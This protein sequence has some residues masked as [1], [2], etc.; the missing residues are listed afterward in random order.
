MTFAELGYKQF[1]DIDFYVEDEY[2]ENFYY[3]IL[4]KLFPDINFSKIFPLGGKYNVIKNAKNTIGDKKKVY[5]VDKDF[6]DLL[7]K[8]ENLENLFYLKQYSVENY[9]LEANPI[10][11]IVMEERPKF[12]RSEIDQKFILGD[13]LTECKNLF[14]EIIP[15]YIVIQKYELGIPNVD[16]S[17]D[18]YCILNLN[19]E[20][21]K[22]ELESYKETIR[23]ALEDKH[24][25]VS[26]MRELDYYKEY[27]KNGDFL[28]HIPGKYI[29]KFLGIR[30]S[31][32]F[33]FPSINFNSLAYRLSKLCTLTSLLFLKSAITGFLS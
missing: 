10:I 16:L 12:Q 25:K 2:Q 3:I 17:Q 30:I 7:N 22:T 15:C 26:F 29:I 6:D 31:Q 33:N 4:K 18:R 11:E 27:F 14:L 23:L 5:I 8:K 19:A 28:N 20:I 24:E 9:L 21:K 32:L 13:F 1:N